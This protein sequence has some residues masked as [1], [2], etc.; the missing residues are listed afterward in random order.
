MRII[1][2]FIKYLYYIIF[3]CYLIYI[4]YYYHNKF[5][6]LKWNIINHIKNLTGYAKINQNKMTIKSIGN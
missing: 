3:Y 6:S 5:I 2:I 4:Q 1:I